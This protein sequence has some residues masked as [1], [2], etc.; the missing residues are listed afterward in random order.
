MKSIEIR[1]VDTG[2]IVMFIAGLFY[3]LLVIHLFADIWAAL[4]KITA[5]IQ[6]VKELFQYVMHYR[7][8][9]KQCIQRKGQEVCLANI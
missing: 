9:H 3:D 1:T 8:R 6:S 7:L 2:V 5:L 4:R